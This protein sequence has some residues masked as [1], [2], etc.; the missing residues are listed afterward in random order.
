LKIIIA[1][2]RRLCPPL[3]I[4]N[5]HIKMLN[6]SST[7]LKQSAASA[8]YSVSFA[9]LQLASSGRLKGSSLFFF[10]NTGCPQ[11]HTKSVVALLAGS[12][13]GIEGHGQ[14]AW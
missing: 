12:E 5:L 9:A 3:F 13:R 10:L 7:L 6:W 8:Y 14:W 11:S 2:L 4:Y 1:L